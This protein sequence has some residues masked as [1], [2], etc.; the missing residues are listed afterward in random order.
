[1]NRHTVD[2]VSAALGVV[3]VGAGVLVMTDAFDRLDDESG[4]WIAVAALVVGIGLIPWNRSRTADSFD[5]ADVAAG[6][7]G[8]EEPAGP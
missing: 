3:T 1:M 5:V 6:A 8:P 4:W 7:E 2:T